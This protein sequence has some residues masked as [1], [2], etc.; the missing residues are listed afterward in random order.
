MH[1]KL[2]KMKKHSITFL[3]LNLISFTMEFA[4]EKPTYLCRKIKKI[5]PDASEADYEKL[6]Q[7]L[8]DNDLSVCECAWNLIEEKR[9]KALNILKNR[10]FLTQ[11]DIIEIDDNIDK[12]Q[13]YDL[14][15]KNRLIV[16]IPDDFP[17]ELKKEIS[18]HFATNFSTEFT[19]DITNEPL[20]CSRNLLIRENSTKD[21]PLRTIVA[22]SFNLYIDKSYKNKSY[23]SRKAGLLHEEQHMLSNHYLLEFL[24]QND[25]KENKK[26]NDFPEIDFNKVSR[27]L[28]LEADIIPATCDSLECAHIMTKNDLSD[29]YTKEDFYYSKV[30]KTHPTRE[31]REAWTQK[32]YNLRKAE[33]KLKNFPKSTRANETILNKIIYFL[34]PPLH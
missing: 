6:V 8:H 19:N 29:H 31:A 33:E 15:N 16:H 3:L 9:S 17:E 23:L 10:R 2:F 24:L 5:K 28:E 34:I 12:I 25:I 13:Q 11:N 14:A 1:E 26:I 32:I 4:K 22:S 7:L 18:D 27:A 30:D 21:K 20:S